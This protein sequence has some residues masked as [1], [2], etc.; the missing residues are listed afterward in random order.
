MSFMD[1]RLEIWDNKA[2]TA[3]VHSYTAEGFFDLEED[4]VT[5][6]SIAD[7]LWLNIKVG[8]AFE[9]LAAGCYFA[10]LNSDSATIA[11]GVKCVAALGCE[12]FPVLVTELTAGAMFSLAL[13][14]YGLHKYLEIYWNNLDTVASAGT[15]NAW[16]GLESL[17][18]LKVQ[19]YPS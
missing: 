9:G 8:T 6:E 2:L 11:S 15:V 1:S 17:S 10:V 5:D 19:K 12:D 4:G 14:R 13:P 18:P 7:G 3:I 16:F